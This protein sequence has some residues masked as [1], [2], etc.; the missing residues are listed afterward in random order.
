MKKFTE[1]VGVIREAEEKQQSSLQKS[2]EEYFKAKLAKYDV[3]SPA[4]LS[5]EEKKKFFNEISADWERGKGVK[6]EAKKEIEK[7]KK[8]AK[9]KETKAPAKEVGELEGSAE[10][11]MKSL[12]KE[13]R[14]K[15]EIEDSLKMAEDKLK[16]WKG[17]KQNSIHPFDPQ[18][19]VSDYVSYLQ[20]T[21]RY[22]KAELEQA[23]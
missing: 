23:N 10:D 1:W 15:T 9:E 13:S 21:I 3:E 8:E 14:S 6:P 18:K 20:D 7:E 12:I 16:K 22:L 2:Y 19:K 11:K 17:V 5:D 4:D